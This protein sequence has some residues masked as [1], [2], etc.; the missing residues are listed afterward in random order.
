MVAEITSQCPNVVGIKDSSGNLGQL[1]LDRMEVKRRFYT[2]VGA[3]HTV[4]VSSAGASVG[5][6]VPGFELEHAIALNVDGQPVGWLMLTFFPRQG[7]PN[8]PE[9]IFFTSINRA[10]LYS[11]LGSLLLA[12]LLG[13]LLSFTMTS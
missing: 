2:L 12:V 1:A 6:K 4:V 5:E 13:G 10:I 8:S 3:D 9:G 11:A 7:S